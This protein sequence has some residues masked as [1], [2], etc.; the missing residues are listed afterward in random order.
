MRHLLRDRTE[1]ASHVITKHEIKCLIGAIDMTMQFGIETIWLDAQN[2]A[3]KIRQTLTIDSDFKK[4]RIDSIWA[5]TSFVILPALG[6]C[7]ECNE[8]L[9]MPLNVCEICSRSIALEMYSNEDCCVLF[10]LKRKFIP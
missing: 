8:T 2:L 9:Y 3:K 6:H 5:E 10:S 1:M 7:S 4:V